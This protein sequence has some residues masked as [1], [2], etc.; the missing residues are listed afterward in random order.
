MIEVTSNE[1]TPAG[2]DGCGRIIPTGEPYITGKTSCCCESYRQLCAEC[3][4]EAVE[5]LKRAPAIRT[6]RDPRSSKKAKVARG[7][8]LT[9]RRPR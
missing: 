8:A 4:A 9:Q 2:C 5:L 6:L 7:E 3:I 1:D